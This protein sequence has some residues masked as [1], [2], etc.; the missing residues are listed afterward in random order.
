MNR[1]NHSQRRLKRQ[2]TI[3]HQWCSDGSTFGHGKT[4][5]EHHKSAE[6]APQT[7]QSTT[8]DDSRAGHQETVIN[9][10]EC[11]QA[12]V[13]PDEGIIG[14]KDQPLHPEGH[15]HADQKIQSQVSNQHPV[16]PVQQR[17]EETDMCQQPSVTQQQK[18]IQETVTIGQQVPGQNCYSNVDMRQQSTVT[19][20]SQHV[21]ESGTMGQP[22]PGQSFHSNAGPGTFTPQPKPRQHAVAS[23]PKPMRHCYSEEITRRYMH[24]PPQPR[25]RSVDAVNIQANHFLHQEN[26]M[27]A[28]EN[29]VNSLQHE[30]LT[31]APPKPA[32]GNNLDDSIKSSPAVVKQPCKWILG[33]SDPQI[34]PSQNQNGTNITADV[35][36]RP[37]QSARSLGT[38]DQMNRHE[39]H[40]RQTGT[41]DNQMTPKYFHQSL[42]TPKRGRPPKPIHYRQA[43]IGVDGTT[44]KPRLHRQS[45]VGAPD[46]SSNSPNVESGTPRG[47]RVGRKVHK[48]IL[49]AQKKLAIGQSSFGKHGKIGRNGGQLSDDH[50]GRVG[51][52]SVESQV[53]HLQPR[54]VNV[55]VIPPVQEYKISSTR[56]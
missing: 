8:E 17:P 53:D 10:G 51:Q 30:Q 54:Y 21:Q 25:Q 2:S 40:Q 32:R 42:D 13:Q 6:G 48:N 35:Q 37:T 7:P 26:P 14:T 36:M 11:L 5:P 28:M 50:G 27:D 56:L 45:N 31:R 20:Q 1:R 16:A 22:V 12:E 9:G 23:H 3:Q 43:N 33:T 47:Q 55:P 41:T 44:P 29:L 18:Q 52:S 24:H 38:V 46:H 4:P 15:P 19:Q 34:S 39:H 49:E